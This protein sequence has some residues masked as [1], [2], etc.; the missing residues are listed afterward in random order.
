MCQ[1]DEKIHSTF[2]SSK[3]TVYDFSKHKILLIIARENREKKKKRKKRN[4]EEK[5]EYVMMRKSA[6]Q[7]EYDMTIYGFILTQHHQ[8]RHFIVNVYTLY[9]LRTC[10]LPVS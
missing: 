10:Y 6:R 8:Q 9:I 1:H 5:Q 7:R 2:Q 3:S 4:K